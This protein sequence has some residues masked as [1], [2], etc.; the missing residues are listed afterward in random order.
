MR[1]GGEWWLVARAATLIAVFTLTRPLPYAAW[2]RLAVALSRLRA[3]EPGIPIAPSQIVR[4]LNTA[5]RVVPGGGNCLIR[6]LTARA[7]LAR[8]GLESEILM[9]VARG[10]SGSL[11]AHA[12]LRHD[13]HLLVGVEGITGYV[14][15]PLPPGHDFTPQLR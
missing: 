3:G 1:S 13:G 9:G 11:R 14:P 4:A 6:A 8:H 10:P 12:W 7:L 15:M 5:S 2:R